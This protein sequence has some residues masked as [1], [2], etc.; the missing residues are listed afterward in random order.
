MEPVFSVATVPIT[1]DFA[2]E[3]SPLDIKRRVF[4]EHQL[5][6]EVEEGRVA[7]TFSKQPT[8]QKHKRKIINKE[9]EKRNPRREI[10]GGILTV[11]LTVLANSKIK[12][13]QN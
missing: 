6:A 7:K 3:S 13:A 11:K 5:S 8:A 9:K 2:A 4:R 10:S 1:N 12:V